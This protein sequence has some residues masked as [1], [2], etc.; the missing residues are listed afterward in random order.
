MNELVFKDREYGVIVVYCKDTRQ[1]KRLGEW[2]RLLGFASIVGP[3]CR[4]TAWEG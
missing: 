4:L 2:A 3:D 1:A